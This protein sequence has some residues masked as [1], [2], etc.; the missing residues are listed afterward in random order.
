MYAS[1]GKRLFRSILDVKPKALAMECYKAYS[2]AS[3]LISSKRVLC[4]AVPIIVTISAFLVLKRTR[5][6]GTNNS[7][8]C[9]IIYIRD[10]ANVFLWGVAPYTIVRIIIATYKSNLYPKSWRWKGGGSMYSAIAYLLVVLMGRSIQAIPNTLYYDIGIRA[11]VIT[12][13]DCTGQAA[14]P[15]SRVALTRADARWAWRRQ[16]AT[17]KDWWSGSPRAS[18]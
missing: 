3:A 12:Y 4:N 18:S 5:I 7:Y 1:P 11:R 17:S 6:H 16:T 15:R 2:T 14:V 9:I 13:S 8:F 10:F